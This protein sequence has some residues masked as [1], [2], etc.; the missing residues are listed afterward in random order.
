MLY[1]CFGIIVEN[2]CAGYAVGEFQAAGMIILYPR[3]NDLVIWICASLH[4][5]NISTIREFKNVFN[6]Q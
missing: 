2:Q 5:V 4:S 6:L 3:S 1:T